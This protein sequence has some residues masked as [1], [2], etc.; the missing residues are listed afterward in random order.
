MYWDDLY[1][2]VSLAERFD[3]QQNPPYHANSSGGEDC[4]RRQGK[5][6]A[7]EQ[8]KA[9]RLEAHVPYEYLSH[10]RVTI[11]LWRD[12]EDTLVTFG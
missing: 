2:C 3:G 12:R 6:L 11:Y 1:E 9:G 8:R 4:R 10:R 5:S 7:R